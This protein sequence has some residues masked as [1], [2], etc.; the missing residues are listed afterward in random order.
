MHLGA[1]RGREP[2]PAG[3]VPTM[4][5]VGELPAVATNAAALMISIPEWLKKVLAI[6]IRSLARDLIVR[7]FTPFCKLRILKGCEYKAA[8]L[9]I[10]NLPISAEVR[11]RRSIPKLRV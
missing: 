3:K 5:E 10:C 6:F 11:Q 8:A 9:A 1:C 2:Q 4:L 7:A